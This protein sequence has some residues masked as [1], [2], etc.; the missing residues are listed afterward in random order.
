M[1]FLASCSGGN[2]Q[3]ATNIASQNQNETGNPI[4]QTAD[5]RAALEDEAVGVEDEDN[6]AEET[7]A[8]EQAGTQT[9]EEESAAVTEAANAEATQKAEAELADIFEVLEEVGHNNSSGHL[10]WQEDGSYRE[11]KTRRRLHLVRLHPEQDA[12]QICQHGSPDDP[13]TRVRPGARR[14]G[15]AKCR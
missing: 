13:A 2:S 6:S 15:R 12:H 3:L 5:A 9:A 4:Q 11:A 1:L 8:A 7:Q 14:A 10:Q